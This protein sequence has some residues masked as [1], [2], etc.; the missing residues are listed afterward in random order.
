MNILP[1]STRSASAAAQGFRAHFLQTPRLQTAGRRDA[2][3]SV[4]AAKATSELVARTPSRVSA[5]S[6]YGKARTRVPY[7]NAL[8]AAAVA[9]LVSAC[10]PADVTP[11]PEAA[12][13]QPATHG[14][15]A[16]DMPTVVITASRERPKAIG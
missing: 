7:A 2:G 6:Y 13:V 1:T 16:A 9:A 3:A 4:I 5:M 8:Y 11:A 14:A 12:V 10:A 15:E